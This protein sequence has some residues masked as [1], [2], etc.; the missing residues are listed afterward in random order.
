MDI[1]AAGCSGGGA[2]FD[3][4]HRNNRSQRAVGQ[5]GL[6]GREEH[7]QTRCGFGGIFGITVVFDHLIVVN[8]GGTV[9]RRTRNPFVETADFIVV[10]GGRIM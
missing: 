2:G 10:F 7:A 4:N 1:H 5:S 6:A 8:R 3:I 9:L